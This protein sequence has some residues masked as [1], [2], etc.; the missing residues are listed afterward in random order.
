MNGDVAMRIS[1]KKLKDLNN[2]I[3][4]RDG[5]MCIACGRY[6]PNGEKFHHERNGVKSDCMELG[7]TLCYQCHQERH[8]GNVAKLRKKCRDYLASIYG[9]QWHGRR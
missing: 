2:A 9:E 8:F 1:G 5:N 7:V 4:E 3:H 6:V